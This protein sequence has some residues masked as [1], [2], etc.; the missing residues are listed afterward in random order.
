MKSEKEP[1]ISVIIT[2]YNRPNIIGRAVK[3]VAKQNYENLEIVVVD[4]CSED[5]GIIESKAKKSSLGREI[6]VINHESNRG[7]AATRNT[8]LKSASGELVS[9]LDDDDGWRPTKLSKQVKLIRKKDFSVEV[10]YC[11]ARKLREGS[12]K[13]IAKMSPK[14]SGDI[15]SSV[16]KGKLQ[17]IS[18]SNLI[19]KGKIRSIGGFDEGLESHIDYDIWMK[20]AKAGFSTDYVDECLVNIYEGR[21]QMTHRYRERTSSTKKFV[22]KWKP[23]LYEIMGPEKSEEF[24]RRLSISVLSRQSAV[25]VADGDILFA[26]KCLLYL[27]SENTVRFRSLK[28]GVRAFLGTLRKTILNKGT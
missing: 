15:K 2:S 11:G 21:D 26:T 9:F 8:G 13:E 6:E 12:D 16:E 5:P 4:D 20:M 14:M 24:I 7:L 1:L 3:S 27:F 17:T 19:D 28:T 23:F 25:A 18:S 10:V 22:D